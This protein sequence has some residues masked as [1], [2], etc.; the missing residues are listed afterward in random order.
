MTTT[1]D[2]R[3]APE[4]WR[5][6]PGA[7]VR[8]VASSKAA[9]DEPPPPAG[10]WWVVDRCPEDMA[11]AGWWLMPRDDVALAW[12]SA[13]RPHPTHGRALAVTGRLLM[14]AATAVRVR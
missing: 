4:G 2:R 1:D 12:S 9:P 3:L 11:H 5:P 7:H 8:V 14:P 13:R 10:V 6:K